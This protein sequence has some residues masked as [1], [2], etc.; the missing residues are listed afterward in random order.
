MHANKPPLWREIQRTNFTDW[1]ELCQF[2]E[3]EVDGLR[4]VCHIS[5]FPLNLP[6]R[7][8][9]KIEKGSINDP[10]LRQ[11]LPTAAE[12]IESIG[13]CS[14]P[15]G[16]VPSQKTSKLLHKYQGR[17]LL[18]CSSACAMHCRYCFRQ[19]FDYAT[20]QKG[21]ADELEAIRKEE[22]LSEI[23]LSGGDP[24]SLSNRELKS[25][26]ESLSA[27]SH[28]KRIRFHTRFPIGIPERIDPEFLEIMK[29]CRPQ[30]FFTIHSNHCQEWD[31][32][33]R[34]AMKH[35]QKLGIPILCQ[36]VL[37]KGV[38]D[39]LE[40]LQSLC[41]TLVDQGIIPYYLHQLD[42][43]LGTL[44]F[45]VSETKGLELMNELSARLSG[46]AVPKY[47]RE[48]AG[49]KNKTP[50]ISQTFSHPV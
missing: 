7:L 33:V 37:L 13:F 28:V 22:S 49:E 14:D 12:K 18:L 16:D 6:R 23:I 17:A 20:S 10:I 46:Y 2:L 39:D 50:L 1:K 45:E 31:D 35:I 38:N 25:L 36:T 21:F 8:A 32:D 30:I 4:D 44:H 34:S 47:V 48:I 27:I 40:T 29:A 3:L 5:H 9:E 42:K 15:V 24:L 41:E 26:I 43:V 19:H 11:F